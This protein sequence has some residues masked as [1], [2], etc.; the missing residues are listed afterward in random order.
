MARIVLLYSEPH[1]NSVK[2]QPYDSVTMNMEIFSG[3][4]CCVSKQTKDYSHKITRDASE[5]KIRKS[6]PS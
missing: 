5:I 2:E 1:V 4:L 6:F 3:V